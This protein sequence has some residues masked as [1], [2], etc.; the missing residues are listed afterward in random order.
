MS[1]HLPRPLATRTVRSRPEI[2]RWYVRVDH[3]RG[4]WHVEGPEVD[5]M[6]CGAIIGLDDGFVRQRLPLKNLCKKCARLDKRRSR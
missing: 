3:T 2:T 5:T 1:D 6:L 4:E